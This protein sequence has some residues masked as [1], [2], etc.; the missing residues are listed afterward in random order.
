MAG[1]L[2]RSANLVR[3]SWW[4]SVSM[5]LT[6][7]GVALLLGPLLGALLLILTPIP[8]GVANL[9]SSFVYALAIPFVAIATT[10]LFFDLRV[11]ERLEPRRGPAEVLPAEV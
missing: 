2:R 7:A 6:V 1:A 11:R 8:F 5:L 9:V 10:Y 4:R 3:G